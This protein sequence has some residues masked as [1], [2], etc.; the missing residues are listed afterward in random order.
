MEIIN[1]FSLWVILASATL[2]IMAGSI[3]APVLNLMRQGLGIDPS[4]VGLIITTHG[5]FIAIF[6]PLMGS[7]I[8]RFGAKRPC[9]L[10]LV[11]YGLAGGSGL[12]I[13]SYWVLLVSRALLGIGVA[14]FFNSITVMIL[15]LY[16]GEE[17]NKVMGWRGSANSVGGILWPLIGGSL[18]GLSWHL[19]FA[20]YL[21]GIPLGFLLF[22]TV[23]ETHKEITGEVGKQGSVLGVF[24]DHPILFANYGLMLLT[25]IL[26]YVNVV[27]LPQLLERMG[28]SNPFHIGLFITIMALSA[29]LASLMY[30]RIKSKLSYRIIVFLALALWTVGF[31]AVSQAFHP[32]MIATSVVLFGIGQGMVMPTVMVWVGEIVPVSFRGRFSSYLGTFGF[33]GQFLSPLIFAPILLLLGLNGVFLVAA[34]ICAL[35]FLVWV[36]SRH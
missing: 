10:G 16:G 3:I 18:G 24:K 26:L 23:P 28:I 4:S 31:T 8:D 1:R 6:S 7:L 34:G 17:R 20:V 30:G 2:T 15:N 27:F 12:L 25:S 5:L 21:V 36:T 14:A 11:L 9:A 22:V 35:S 33:I 32:L 29:G 13:N 19:P